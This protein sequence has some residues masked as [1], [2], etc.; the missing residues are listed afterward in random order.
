[1]LEKGGKW[2]REGGPKMVEGISS[3]CKTGLKRWSGEC[4]LFLLLL[5]DYGPN[6]PRQP[7]IAAK[8]CVGGA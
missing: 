4:T 5:L 7:S 2:G 1:M 3:V 8:V 6:L